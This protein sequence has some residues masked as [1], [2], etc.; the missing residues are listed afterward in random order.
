MS[1]SK[2]IVA[3][4]IGTS[5]TCMVVGEVH[6]DGSPTFIGI[7]EV[8]SEGIAAGE[9]VNQNLACL[10][11]SDAWQIAQD[12]AC[13]DI[14]SVYL[15]VT[16]QH[17]C[18]ENNHVLYP[19]PAGDETIEPDHIELAC[20]MAEKYRPAADRCVINKI[21]GNFCVD[22]TNIYYDPTGERG[23][24]L[25][26]DCHVIHGD[27]NRL[28]KALLCV[29]QVPLEVEA[30]VFA[31][32]ATAHMV[33]NRKERDACSLLIDIG[34]G[35]SDYICYYQGD[36][37]VSGSLPCAGN[38]ITRDIMRQSHSPMPWKAAESLKIH[39]GNAFGNEHETAMATYRDDDGSIYGIPRG[40]LYTVIRRRLSYILEYVRSQLP[41]HIQRQKSLLVYITG[42]TSLMLG[43]DQ[44]AGSIFRT[45]V[46]KPTALGIGEEYKY[47]ADPKYCTAL[48]LIYYAI[49]KEAENAQPEQPGLWQRFLGLFRRNK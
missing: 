11:V 46:F 47:Q 36:V 48:G 34:A 29:R 30:M 38:D 3:L 9:I 39:Q 26:V 5:K 44:L 45:A 8:P 2:I 6:A 49:K 18:G 37:V 35:T 20:E 22:S 41:E 14:Q 28:Q 43:L 40:E 23:K 12:H 4:E 31:P 32:L 42:G 15:S 25:E 33:F 16:G 21:R 13:V 19:L 1:E 10:N 27:K 17:I 7:G 24:T